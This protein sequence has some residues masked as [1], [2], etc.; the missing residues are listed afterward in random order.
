VEHPGLGWVLP[1]WSLGLPCGT[2]LVPLELPNKWIELTGALIPNDA[3]PTPQGT[4]MWAQIESSGK[5]GVGA[6]SLAHNPLRGRGAGW[7]SGMGL[8]RVDKL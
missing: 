1:P 2:S 6:R 3:L 4:Q 7:S 5:G 8:G